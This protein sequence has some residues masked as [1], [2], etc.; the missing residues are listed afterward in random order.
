METTRGRKMLVAQQLGFLLFETTQIETH[1][2]MY[3][4]LLCLY[5]CIFTQPNKMCYNSTQ[6]QLTFRRLRWRKRP[7]VPR[8]A[9]WCEGGF[10]PPNPPLLAV[11]RVIFLSLNLVHI[12]TQTLTYKHTYSHTHTHTYASS[13]LKL[14]YRDRN[15]IIK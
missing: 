13:V 14:T 5:V 11:L 15:G 6:K 2:S 1:V 3:A 9:K 8:L 4:Q 7:H 12:C 10:Y